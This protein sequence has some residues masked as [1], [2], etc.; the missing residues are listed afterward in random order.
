MKSLPQSKQ[1]PI[2][3]KMV[4]QPRTHLHNTDDKATTL[5]KEVGAKF[6][7]DLL[8]IP[9]PI[10]AQY[11]NVGISKSTYETGISDF[12]KNAGL[13]GTGSK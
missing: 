6:N 9:Q 5:K 1:D 11:Q 12:R 8:W 3:Q 2:A 13:S 10:G 4:H 7:N